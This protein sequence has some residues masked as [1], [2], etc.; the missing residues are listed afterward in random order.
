MGYY[1]DYT[2]EIS[3]Q[4]P[5]FERLKREAHEVYPGDNVY[6]Y[7][8][9]TLINGDTESV[10]WY[11]YKDD[12]KS[13]SLEWP[14]V[15]FTMK[16]IGEDHEVWAVHFMNGYMQEAEAKIT[17]DDPDPT[18][19]LYRDEAEILAKQ[20]RRAELQEMLRKVQEELDSL[21]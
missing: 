5:I 11:G 9:Q 16:C 14:N 18:V 15:L 8:V 2:L 3:G 19:L 7:S 17:F 6:N 1:T 13:L 21:S 20:E 10:K 12:M 4:G